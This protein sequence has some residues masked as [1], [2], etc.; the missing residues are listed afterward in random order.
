MLR[1]VCKA[2]AE[3]LK[4]A[5]KVGRELTVEE[6]RLL[7]IQETTNEGRDYGVALRLCEGKLALIMPA[8]AV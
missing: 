6:R 2:N 1:V 3:I 8:N 5:K 4:R 7:V